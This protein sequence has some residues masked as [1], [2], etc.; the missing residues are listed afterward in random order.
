MNL[1]LS[2]STTQDS[3]SAAKSTLRQR[4]FRQFLFS[5]DELRQKGS[6]LHS[7]L[8][9]LYRQWR[10]GDL[11][12]CEVVAQYILRFLQ[13][14]RPRDY[15]GG[16]HGIELSSRPDGLPPAVR[17]FSRLSF[18]STPLAV[19]RAL[20]LWAEGICRLR[21]LDEIP[22]AMSVLRWQAQGERVV[23]CLFDASELVSMVN[24]VRDPLGFVL[25]DLVHADHFYRF[26]DWNEGQI[27]FY[28]E[29]LRRIE[30]GEFSGLLADPHLA[31][32]LE[33]IIADMNSHPDHL[34]KT[35]ASLIAAGSV[36][37]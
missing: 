10:N 9:P 24:G 28:S 6:E 23:T 26:R 32:R 27:Q 25:H 15:R 29:T 31:E 16:P 18:R 34:R 22:E 3:P 35:L 12:E 8:A 2:Q 30:A 13:V 21:L 7:V 1:D 19:N 5:L 20:V 33:Y 4:R 11:E 36:R 37:G 14:M 17:E